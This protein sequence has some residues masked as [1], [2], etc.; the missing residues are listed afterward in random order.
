M[1]DTL[2][3]LWQG[4]LAPMLQSNEKSEEVEI[5]LLCIE[6]QIK[7]LDSLLDEKGKEELG[8][9]EEYYKRLIEIQR[10]EA[11]KQ[12]FSLSTR[13]ITESL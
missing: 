6:R 5:L 10:E 12:G 7:H 1:E 13:L 2:K 3:S 8:N 11:F 9:L 4:R